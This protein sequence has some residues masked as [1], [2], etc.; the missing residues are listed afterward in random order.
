M[1]EKKF[2]KILKQC[3]E[4]LSFDDDELEVVVNAFEKIKL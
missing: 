4:V 1:K 3:N 2:L